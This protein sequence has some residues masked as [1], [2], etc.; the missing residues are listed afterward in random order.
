MGPKKKDRTAVTVRLERALAAAQARVDGLLR[1][2][3]GQMARFATLR[4]TARALAELRACA[5]AA[6]HSLGDTAAARV[7]LDRLAAL[8]GDGPPACSHLPGAGTGCAWCGGGGGGGGAGGGSTGASGGGGDASP[9]PPAWSAAAVDAFLEGLPHL[10][11][12]RSLL[13]LEE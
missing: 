9:P 3:E 5:A 7:D 1:D 13:H 4:L 10:H 8:V 2:R 12:G 6:G 11:T